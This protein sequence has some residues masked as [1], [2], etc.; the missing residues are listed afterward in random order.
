MDGLNTILHLLWRN[1]P[2]EGDPSKRVGATS[3]LQTRVIYEVSGKV[4]GRSLGWIIFN[5]PL[6]HPR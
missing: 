5:G 4:P 2:V 3:H 1:G 6:I